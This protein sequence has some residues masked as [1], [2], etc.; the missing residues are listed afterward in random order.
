MRTLIVLLYLLTLGYPN[1]TAQETPPAEPSARP[2]LVDDVP[3]GTNWIANTATRVYYPVGCP[4]TIDISEADRLY[5]K[6]EAALRVGGFTRGVECGGPAAPATPTPIAPQAAATPAGAAPADE[7]SEPEKHARK[8]F[9]FNAGLGYGSLGCQDCDG[10][11]GSLSGGLALGGALSQKVMLGVGTNG[12]TKSEFGATLTVGTLVALIRFYPS[13]TGGFFLLAGLGAGTIRAEVS[14][15]GSETETGV[16]ALLG[17]GYDI[18]VGS[19]VSLTPFWNGF[20]AST[21]NSDAN[22]GQIG[23]GITVH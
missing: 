9:W 11:E 8:G 16:G 15:F 18:R 1:V 5:Y 17:L 6:S 10:R 13:A 23:L 4:I 21:T 12:W 19:N 14:D 3:E 22:V 7:T 20:A 2:V